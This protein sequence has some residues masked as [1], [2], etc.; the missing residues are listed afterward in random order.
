M[1]D[2]ARVRETIQWCRQRL[3]AAGVTAKSLRSFQLEPNDMSMRGA[4]IAGRTAEQIEA[5]RERIVR[6]L[7]LKR[8]ALLGQ[9]V[10]S[11]LESG[12]ILAFDLEATYY[13]GVPESISD[14]F[15]DAEDL[16]PWDTW[17]TYGPIPTLSNNFLISWVPLEFEAVVERAVEA[18]MADAY[19]W[20]K[21]HSA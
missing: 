5:D 4:Y 7:C 1:I 15:F 14:G 19:E 21:S 10:P 20:V 11:T 17:I 6:D 3:T 8:A 16:P 12:R 2:Q 9:A 18:H 13:D